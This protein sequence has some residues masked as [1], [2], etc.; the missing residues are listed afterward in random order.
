MANGGLFQLISN[1]GK[2]DKMLMATDFLT[3]RLKKIRAIRMNDPSIEDK[4]PTLADIERTHVL[5]VSAHFKPFAAMAYE[6]NKVRPTGQTL[7]GSQVTF[8]IPQFGDFFGDMCLHVILT[9]PVLTQNGSGVANQCYGRWVD[10]PGQNLCQKV[11]FSVN[12][13]PLDEYTSDVYNMYQQF[14][15]NVNKTLGWNRCVGQQN[16][17]SGF[18]AQDATGQSLPTVATQTWQ[19]VCSITTGPQTPVAV[20]GGLEMF[21][22]LLFWFNLDP[23]LAI[24]SVSIPYGQRFININ[25]QSFNNMFTVI[26]RG[27]GTVTLTPSTIDTC[28]LYI[29]NLFVNPEIH[30]IFIKRIGFNLIRVHRLQTNNVNVASYQQ[31][32]QNLKWPIET[33]YVGL[34]PSGPN[35]NTA[36]NVTNGQFAADNWHVYN[37]ATLVQYQDTKS[38]NGGAS[39][40]NPLNVYAYTPT[41][42]NLSVTAHGVKLYDAFPSGFF[43][44]YIPTTYGEDHIKTPY[45]TGLLMITFNLYPGSYQPSGHVNLSRAREFYLTY[46]SSYVNSNNPA[47]LI[48]LGTAINFLLIADGGAVLRYTT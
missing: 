25:L 7:Y 24:P 16:P 26:T 2:Q 15:V 28:E 36:F 30:D 27:N 46:I 10:F 5:F 32:L 29:N 20:P 4:M 3:D 18:V 44:S 48:V 23:R 11:S 22:P 12:G 47:N 40:S 39:Y 9:A 34:Q 6:Y 41:I 1:D 13:N 21:I 45:D 35:G 31:L 14:R 19:Q 33:V 38:Y 43:N 8:S 17:I 42:D 37:A